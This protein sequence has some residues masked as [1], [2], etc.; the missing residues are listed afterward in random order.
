MD[1]QSAQRFLGG[2][3][4]RLK[5]ELRTDQVSRLMYSTDASLYQMVPIGVAFP[6]DE[7]DVVHIVRL[8]AEERIPVLARGAGT[9][10]AGQTVTSGL[11]LDFSRHM[12]RILRVDPEKRR[13]RVEPGVVLD[14]LNHRL[15]LQS[16]F[17]APDVA[18]ANRATLGGMAGNNSA[19]VR[20]IRYGKTVD[21]VVGTRV[22]LVPGECFEFGQL[23]PDELTWLLRGSDR[24]AELY[25]LVRDLAQQLAPEIE[26]RYPKVLR[27]VSGYNL[28]EFTDSSRFNMSKLLVGSEGTLGMVTEL[29]LNLEPL[30][31][32]RALA[33]LH[34]SDLLSALRAVPAI[35]AHQ[36][37]AVELIDDQALEL[38][39]HHPPMARLCR[40][41]VR[42]TPKALLIVE[43]SGELMTATAD[44][45]EDLSVDPALSG[46]VYHVEKILSAEGQE[47]VWEVR[48]NTDAI[49]NRVRDDY[50]PQPF[51]EDSC[52]PVEHLA[53]YIA[54]V[55]EL[56]RKVS[57]R[58]AVFAHVSVGVVHVRPFLNLRREED[59]RILQALSEEVFQLVVKYGGS[60]SGEHGDG[61]ARSYKLP[62][63]FGPDLYDAF[64]SIKRLFDPAGVM[65]P[66]KI[67]DAP[68][69]TDHLRIHPGYRT[70]V[71]ETGYRFREEKGFDRAVE[72]C[73]GVGQ[74]RKTLSGVMCPSYMATRD[75]EASTRG[76]ANA[77]R[78]AL[79]GQLGELGLAEPRLYE[80]LDLCLECKSCKAECPS[81]VDMAR[82]KAEFLHQY[83]RHHSR[84]PAKRLVA[85]LPQFAAWMS[86]VARLVNPLASFGPVQRSVQRI[87]RF[88]PRRPLP[89][90]AAPRWTRRAARIPRLTSGARRRVVLFADTFTEYFDP[91]PGTAAAELL[92]SL[93][94][95]VRVLRPG[96]CGRPAISSGDLEAA[97]RQGN[98]L[99]QAFRQLE[100]PIVVLEP[101]CYA[102]IKDDYRDLL[103]DEDLLNNV[104]PRVLSLE[105][106]LLL[107]ETAEEVRTK[108]TA[109]WP[110][111]LLHGH[112]Q[113]RS[114]IGIEP[115]QSALSLV[116]RLEIRTVPAGC[117]GMAGVFGYEEGHYE[118]SRAIAGRTLLPALEATPP[119]IPVVVSGFSCRTQVLH[120]TGRKALHPA[121]FLCQCR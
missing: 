67:I 17:F 70:T 12:R 98:E 30:P 7:E 50:K 47:A 73:T 41:F 120:L 51:I 81:S 94:W 97:R 32:V 71:P 121:E 114:V 88:D 117:C 86:P 59:V 27:R 77:L 112:C 106:F 65:N 22:V 107:P 68:P 80:V 45:V 109:K 87:L 26:R 2:V 103:D 78:A 72:L 49:L 96:C 16:L 35:L 21:H 53:D 99:L 75:E 15:A 101:S 104:L 18:T 89:V 55:E 40:S 61:L 91:T 5:N 74:C 66:G 64:R 25:R 6:R 29:E 58:L 92:E 8:A 63:F 113:Q 62:E 56:G 116:G 105:E 48:K 79:A 57:R 31:A 69:P 95:D 10:L 1:S 76:R 85:K 60:W 9:S 43:F 118:I 111:V 28:D 44:A 36:P 13:V 83:Y 102:T 34:F 23:E 54:E 108:L 33:V 52:V 93:G 20:S 4:E 90:P 38:A 3:R 42:G 119:E 82:L 19:G 100:G 84:P 46:S 11:V 24:Q 110:S 14:E 39:S 115:T 37:T